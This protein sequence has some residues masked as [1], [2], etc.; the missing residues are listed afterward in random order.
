MP[1]CLDMLRIALCRNKIPRHPAVHGIC[2]VCFEKHGLPFGSVYA[3]TVS[4]GSRG[5]T[6]FYGRYKVEDLLIRRLSL[7]LF[8]W[9]R[10]TCRPT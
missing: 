7:L 1:A 8:E 5:I 4:K 2:L 10:S 9:Q 3:R 6:I